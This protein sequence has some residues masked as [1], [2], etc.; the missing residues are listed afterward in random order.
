MAKISKIKAGIYFKTDAEGGRRNPIY[1]KYRP[2]FRYENG[3]QTD[4][5]V[6][7]KNEPIETGVNVDVEIELLHPDK[8]LN[9]KKGAAFSLIEGVRD[10]ARGII[11]ELL[12]NY[13]IGEIYKYKGQNCELLSLKTLFGKKIAQI[14]F[15][16]SSE[17]QE[18]NVSELEDTEADITV[19]HLSFLAIAARIRSALQQGKLLSPFESSIVPLPHQ[20]LALEK[21]MSGQY[22]RFLLADEV[23]MGK[24][25]EAGLILK[26]MKLR[27]IVKR[28][29]IMTPVSAMTQWKTELKKHF[30][31]DFHLY[32]TELINAMARTL[33]RI[34]AETPINIWQQHNQVLVPIDALRPI[35]TRQG[36][37]KEKVEQHNRFRIE[38]VLEADFDLLIIDECHKV[39]GSTQVVSR[40]QMADI[41]TSAIPNVLLLSATPHRGKS[42]HFRRILK[43]LDSDAF[44]GDGMP[45]LEELAPYVV[46]TEKRQAIDYEGNPLFNKRRT[47]KLTVLY[48]ENHAKQ[49][50]LYEKVT[51]YVIKGFNRAETER[52]VSYGFVMTLFQ[53]LMS[54]STQAILEAMEKRRNRLA[55]NQRST[56]DVSQI[57]I[58][59]LKGE[60]Q[61]NL[62]FEEKVNILIEQTDLKDNYDDEVSSL[63]RLILQARECR[64]T[65]LDAK[66]TFLLEK[67]TQ[68]KR[69]EDNPD[70]K[71]LIF[72]E[73]TSTQGMLKRELTTRGGYKVDTINGSMNFEKR[74]EALKHFKGDA[75]ILVSTDAAGESL[76]MQFAHVII[77]YDM[78]WNPMVIEQRIGRVDRIGQTFEVRALNLMLE[79]SIDKRVYEVVEEKLNK[80]MDEL[81]IDK[82]ADVL[83]STMDSDKIRK[84][85]ETSL[86]NPERFETESANWL[87]DIKNKLLN[88]KSTEGSLPTLDSAEIKA[89][90]ARD[91]QNSPI[92]IWTERLTESYL[93]SHK[94]GFERLT[95]GLK[96]RFPNHKEQIYTFD[97][98]ASLVNPI[99]EPLSLQH[100]IVQTMLNEAVAHHKEQPIPTIRLKNGLNTEGYWSLWRL[101]VKNSF[102]EAEMTMP[103]F[104][105]SAGDNY[106]SFAKDLW[107]IISNGNDVEIIGKVPRIEAQT[108][109]E[110]TTDQA[111]EVLENHYANMERKVIEQTEKIRQNKV[112]GFIFQR[113]QMDKIGIANIRKARLLKLE[114]E[115][116]NWQQTFAEATSIVPHLECLIIVKTSA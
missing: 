112:R 110:T 83:D 72:T 69:E 26:E 35:E 39:G 57:D 31:E 29:L 90:K 106:P 3:E 42:D 5:V 36:W 44:A 55:G 104:V 88:Y 102:E 10:V 65:E 108:I 66:T 53:R 33:G 109:F 99:P 92:P 79:N 18:V 87:E 75:Q 47:E 23:G 113:K 54:S 37:S 82:T 101:Q 52:N 34:D 64:T 45:S 94:I 100:A 93:L 98:K 77:N 4:C 16:I 111:E 68:L 114:K 96:F 86:L 81:G 78:P 63:D 56:Q 67:L 27:G 30:N 107:Q 6:Y 24:T 91:Y 41:L 84:L 48:Q 103:L 97:V 74:Q 73:F 28:V 46:R 38:S 71:V 95:D 62:D 11:K 80:I 8:I 43:L 25:I 51:E 49:Q 21:V 13:E 85:Y 7:L 61:L 20:I 116:A 14:R 115:T 17:L 76:N 59:S 89:E 15:L 70:V 105:S 60:G 1:D 9:L 32:D 2:S 40:Y 12:L 50:K 19:A 22:M 58:E